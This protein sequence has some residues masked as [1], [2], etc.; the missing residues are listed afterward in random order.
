MNHEPFDDAM[1]RCAII[2]VRAREL[3][4]I[5][6]R[7]GRHVGPEFDHHFSSGRFHDRDFIHRHRFGFLFGFGIFMGGGIGSER[8]SDACSHRVRKQNISHRPSDHQGA[9][10]IVADLM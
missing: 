2:K 3:L 9:L 7:L 10:T 5:L 6:D 4:E 1:K 8:Q